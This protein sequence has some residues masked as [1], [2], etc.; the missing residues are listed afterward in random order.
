MAS[1]HREVLLTQ[2]WLEELQTGNNTWIKFPLKFLQLWTS[3]RWGNPRGQIDPR[4]LLFTLLPAFFVWARVTHEIFQGEN[5]LN[6][7]KFHADSPG[8]D[9]R[10]CSPWLPHSFNSWQQRPGPQRVMTRTGNFRRFFPLNFMTNLW[11]VYT[12]TH[13]YM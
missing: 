13:T 6:R 10:L 1:S 9:L 11:G 12:H 4:C 7:K 3:G 8:P 2:R 5:S